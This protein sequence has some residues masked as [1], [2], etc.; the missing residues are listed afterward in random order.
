MREC[1]SVHVGQAGVQ[2]GNA[3]WELYCL[4]HGLQP[5][6]TLPSDKAAVADDSFST[7]FSETGT[8]K[9]VPRAVFLDLE[10][11]V[12]DEIRTGTYRQLFHPEQL[13]SGKEDAANNYARGHYTVG[14]EIVDLVLDRIRKLADS[15]GRNKNAR[16]NKGGA[17]GKR[18]DTLGVAFKEK[19]KVVYNLK[20]EYLSVPDITSLLEGNE[21][22]QKVFGVE[23][24][25][26]QDAYNLDLHNLHQKLLKHDN[27]KRVQA[28]HRKVGYGD[29]GIPTDKDENVKTVAVNHVKMKYLAEKLPFDPL[30]LRG[31]QIKYHPHMEIR[32]WD[33]QIKNR[34]G[35]EEV[36]WNKANYVRLLK[37]EY[38]KSLG[39]RYDSYYV[40]KREIA[41]NKR[42]VHSRNN[43]FFRWVYYH[44]DTEEPYELHGKE[45]AQMHRWTEYKE[46][47]DEALRAIELQD[48]QKYAHVIKVLGIPPVYVPTYRLPKPKWFRNHTISTLTEAEVARLRAKRKHGAV[49]EEEEQNVTMP[50][51]PAKFNDTILGWHNTDQNRVEG[52]DFHYGVPRT[53]RDPIPLAGPAR[54]AKADVQIP[55]K[56]V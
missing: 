32:V 44:T 16:K 55:D 39:N 27:F 33:R 20:Q 3:C 29:T 1:I 48:I 22:A 35:R 8:G 11:S 4:E 41:Q 21:E 38:A 37:A 49:S 42:L 13:V 9:H 25:D 18:R 56:T 36:I 10:P 34:Q 19:K 43:F 40:Y 5:D 26:Q 23:L 17:R 15:G 47:R 12:V 45:A 24:G 54:T 30:K 31:P 50:N 52:S 14:K 46:A 51:R 2:M 53:I 7:F 28:K 6:G